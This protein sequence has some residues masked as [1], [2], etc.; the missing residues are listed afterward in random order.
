M[1]QGWAFRL[2][3]PT[4][5]ERL[6]F[7]PDRTDISEE[8]VR[9]RSHIDQFLRR[10]ATC[11]RATAASSS[12]SRQE[13]VRE[14][15]TIGSK[16]NDAEITLVRGGDEDRVL[17]GSASRCK[18]WSEKAIGRWLLAVGYWRV[19]LKRGFQ[20]V[21]RYSHQPTANS[22]QP[23][24]NA[25]LANCVIVSGPSGVGK[26]TIIPLVR[27]RVWRPSADER[28]R[29]HPPAAAGRGG[30]RQLPLP[31]G[32]RV[33]AAGSPPGEF[34]E[35]VEVFGRGHWYGTLMSGGDP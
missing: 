11:P 31:L 9:L 23:A 28:L 13:M 26:S 18:T 34:L 15:N 12:S 1:G 25:G 16:A 20:R 17:S 33:P 19:T 29:H 10:D 3:R 21:R 24:G 6:P 8:T 22:Q 4:W 14:V 2:S 7:S 5:C 27:K 35:A 32:R 30:R